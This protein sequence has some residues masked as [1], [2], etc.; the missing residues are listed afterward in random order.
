MKQ[1][2]S[3]EKLE[4]GGPLGFL[5]LQFASKYQKN[6]KGT[7]WRQKNQKSRKVPKQ[8]QRD[9]STVSSGFVSYV[10]NGINE[11]GTLCTN[12]DV[13]PLPVQ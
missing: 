8:N 4:R 2:H 12:L 5:I 3:A 11:W 9:D 7:L 6:S 13:F 1:S 10:E